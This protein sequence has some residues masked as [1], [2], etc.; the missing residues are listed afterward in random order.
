M[1]RVK[2]LETLSLP[3]P[4]MLVKVR[5]ENV[6]DEAGNIDYHGK[7][8]IYIDPR[9]DVEFAIGL[10]PWIGRV[11]KARLARKNYVKD[12]D[13]LTDK[14][15]NEY[16]LGPTAKAVYERFQEVQYKAQQRIQAIGGKEYIGLFFSGSGPKFDAEGN[17][18]PI[19]E[20]KIRLR[21]KIR[22]QAEDIDI[23]LSASVGVLVEE[24][25]RKQ[26]FE[27]DEDG[28]LHQRYISDEEN[29]L[30]IENTEEN[31]RKVMLIRRT[32]AA[33]LDMLADLFGHEA[34]HFLEMMAKTSTLNLP[35]PEE[36]SI[37]ADLNF[38]GTPPPKCAL[39]G[40]EAGH[41]RHGTMECPRGKRSRTLGYIDFGPGIFTPPPAEYPYTATGTK[42]VD[43]A[44]RM[45][46]KSFKFFKFV[47]R[48]RK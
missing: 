48:T 14:A 3:K 45:D 32:L 11:L 16:V 20:E 36:P 42:Q 19:P 12:A 35:A 4:F 13:I 24:G 15:G 34:A 40:K 5:Q 26:F 22:G 23:R 1:T 46:P 25:G 21:R 39:C 28:K 31:Q 27:E 9:G 2:G 44:Y 8:R 6:Y 10:Q 18:L 17:E 38:D 43:G 30:F 7:V 33:A 41:H 37:T 47:K 29:P